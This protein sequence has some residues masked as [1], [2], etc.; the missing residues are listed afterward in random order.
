M[1]IPCI[2][3][4]ITPDLLGGAKTIMIGNVIQNQFLESRNWPFGSTLSI[5]MMVIVII[6]MLFYLRLS[7]DNE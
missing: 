5:V 7:K 1:F 4:F 6:P 3:E 2:G